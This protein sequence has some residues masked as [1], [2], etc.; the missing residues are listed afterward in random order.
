MTQSNEKK[1]SKLSEKLKE[2]WKLNAWK[3]KMNLFPLY[4]SHKIMIF[5]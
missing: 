3:F 4:Y 1:Q 2:E 5:V